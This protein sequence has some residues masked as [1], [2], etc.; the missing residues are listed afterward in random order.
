MVEQ[1]NNDPRKGADLED[2]VRNLRE[3]NAKLMQILR[4]QGLL[5]NP[6]TNLTTEPTNITFDHSDLTITSNSINT[7]N[8]ITHQ[9]ITN[10]GQTNQQNFTEQNIHGNQSNLTPN[11]N[12]VIQS[13][14]QPFVQNNSNTLVQN[15][16]NLIQ[17]INLLNFNNVSLDS[18]QSFFASQNN[19]VYMP[20]STSSSSSTTTTMTTTTTPTTTTSAMTTTT[21]TPTNSNTKEL[22]PSNIPSLLNPSPMDHQISIRPKPSLLHQNQELVPVIPKMKAEHYESIARQY[23]STN[24]ESINN[25]DIDPN[26]P[27]QKYPRPIRPKPSSRGHSLQTYKPVTINETKSSSSSFVSNHSS[28]DRKSVV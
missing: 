18:I 1:D 12:T 27:K 9:H 15:N 22:R 16:T 2:T 21:A 3:E 25:I 10:H 28:P 5:P 19:V 24:N 23:S 20:N 17:P 26:D 11:F 7:T 14:N 6:T 13:T 4:A 8:Q